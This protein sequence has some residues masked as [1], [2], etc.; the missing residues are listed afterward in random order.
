MSWLCDNK[1]MT[2]KSASWA[3]GI[4]LWLIS[5]LAM[6]S[7]NLGADWTLA[8]KNF[9][10]WLDYLTSRWMM[11]LGGLGTV[12]LAG[13]VLKSETF[14][15]ELGLAPLPYALWLTMVRYVS[16]LGILVIFADALGLYQVS[17]AVHWPWLLAVLLVMV[18]V[19]ETLSPRL[20]QALRSR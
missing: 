7:F 15:D 12:V 18:A 13:F 14:R 17:F 1:G 2:R 8:G 20:R 5:T 11:P 4:V 3:T 6:L 19:G 16:P 10:D 9:F